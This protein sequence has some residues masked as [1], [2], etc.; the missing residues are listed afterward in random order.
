MSIVSS[1]SYAVTRLRR[2]AWTFYFKQLRPRL[3]KWFIGGA[4]AVYRPYV[5]WRLSPAATRALGPRHVIN[6]ARIDVDITWV[7]KLRCIH[8]NRSCQQAPTEERMTVEQ[9]RYFLEESRERG[10]PWRQIH[11]NG[12]EPTLHPH[13]FEMLDL[14]LDYR[15]RHAPHTH[16]K[17]TT[18]G[19]GEEVA[20]VLKRIPPGIFVRNTSKKS[21][22]Q[23]AFVPLNIAPVD[24]PEYRGADF[25]NGCQIIRDSG[26]GLTPNGYYPC[27]LAGAI[28]RIFGFNLGRMT[29]PAPDDAMEHE[30]SRFC[31]VCGFFRT[32][33]SV[34]NGGLPQLSSSW[35]FAYRAY[36]ERRPE[37]PAYPG[38]ARPLSNA[39]SV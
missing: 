25:R 26:F 6:R 21:C 1:F 3:P 35:E 36:R 10:N 27:V 15:R 9:F 30:I 39:A 28:D 12:G 5:M 17:I 20:E 33:Y 32:N 37:L 13:L 14:L 24:L 31:A 22:Y 34:E 7:C 38:V 8:C 18:S 4:S 23:D 19:H 2:V 16:L 11:L 29:L